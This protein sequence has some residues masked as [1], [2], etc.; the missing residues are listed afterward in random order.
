MIQ[1]CVV[2]GNEYDKCF[3][4]RHDG[5]TDTFDSVWNVPFMFWLRSAPPVD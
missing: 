1:R 4:V 5:K 2:C 3:E